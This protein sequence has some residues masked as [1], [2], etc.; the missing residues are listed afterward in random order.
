MRLRRVRHRPRRL[1]ARRPIRWQVPAA[2]LCPPPSA[3][4]PLEPGHGACEERA[5]FPRSMGSDRCSPQVLSGLVV[6]PFTWPFT[7]PGPDAASAPLPRLWCSSVFSSQ[8]SWLF[9]VG[10]GLSQLLSC[11][12]RRKGPGPG[13][14]GRQVALAL[15]L[16]LSR[17]LGVPGRQAGGP[18]QTGLP[19]V[20]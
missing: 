10:G 19:L 20:C 8:G 12:G 4:A 11:A 13:S 18:A 15:A 9:R 5:W 14:A 16:S 17:R 2:A 1:R 3:P 6:R 7:L